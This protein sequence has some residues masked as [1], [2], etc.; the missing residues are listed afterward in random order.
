MLWEKILILISL[1]SLTRIVVN[2]T[3]SKSFYFLYIVIDKNKYYTK[4]TVLFDCRLGFSK[5]VVNY[6]N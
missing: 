5:I 1:H 3:L 2:A 6:Y 4:N